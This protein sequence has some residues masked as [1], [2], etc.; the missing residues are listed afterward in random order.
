MTTNFLKLKLIFN[1]FYPNI[2]MITMNNHEENMVSISLTRCS[3][4]QLIYCQRRPA[5]NERSFEHL[6]SNKAI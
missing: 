5:I 1:I 4:P 3:K 6:I 2:L